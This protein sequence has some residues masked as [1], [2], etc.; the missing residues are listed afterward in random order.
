MD[1]APLLDEPDLIKYSEFDL[2]LYFN[3]KTEYRGPPTP[4]REIM[5][6]KLWHRR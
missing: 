4:E 2:P 6:E 5:W 3:E 1:I